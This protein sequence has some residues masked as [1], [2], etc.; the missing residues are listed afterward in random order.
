MLIIKLA[1]NDGSDF[2]AHQDLFDVAGVFDCKYKYGNMIIH[3]QR[4]R[5]A[6]HYSKASC[7]NFLVSNMIEL[8]CIGIY[9]R[10]GIINTVNI[11]CKQNGFSADLSSSKSS[12]SIC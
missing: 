4:S 9:I 8:L 1:L 10:I 6:V 12:C 11:L 2:L 5:S 3:R 7:K